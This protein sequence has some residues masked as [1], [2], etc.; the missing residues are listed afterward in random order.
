MW[1]DVQFI[2]FP[3]HLKIVSH[4]SI[5]DCHGIR[6]KDIIF[7]DHRLAAVYQFNGI[8]DAILLFLLID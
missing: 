5:D 8:A 7:L 2:P 6:Q 4:G 1:P 3:L